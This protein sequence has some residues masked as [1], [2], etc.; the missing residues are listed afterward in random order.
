ML[1]GS[2]RIG[3]AVLTTYLPLKPT[4]RDDPYNRRSRAPV[5]QEAVGL[6]GCL[7]K[8][9]GHAPRWCAEEENNVRVRELLPDWDD[10]LILRVIPEGPRG[11]QI[12]ELVD[13]CDGAKF[14]ALEELMEP[15]AVRGAAVRIEQLLQDDRV[16]GCQV[17][18]KVADRGV[19]D[20]ERRHRQRLG[21]VA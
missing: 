11:V 5:P 16:L 6:F 10:P 4:A 20:E 9:L 19:S 13:D 21:G 8:T 1:A 2:R 14:R 17:P 3:P 12:R 18:V 15:D 7:L